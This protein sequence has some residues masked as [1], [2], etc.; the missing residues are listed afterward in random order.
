MREFEPVIVIEVID[1]TAADIVIDVS[2]KA[3]LQQ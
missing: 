2:V 1:L 3:I